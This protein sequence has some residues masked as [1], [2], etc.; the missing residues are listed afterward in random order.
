MSICISDILQVNTDMK[1]NVNWDNHYNSHGIIVVII[2][3]NTSLF[4]VKAPITL[5]A[6]KK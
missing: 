6:R 3:F 4:F 2:F 5:K 1:P